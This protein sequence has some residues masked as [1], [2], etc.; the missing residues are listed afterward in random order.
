MIGRAAVTT[1]RP[2][3]DLGL[4]QKSA[5]RK[6]QNNFLA[7]GAN[8]G[9]ERCCSKISRVDIGWKMENRMHRH[10]L[11]NALLRLRRYYRSR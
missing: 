5:S 9:E 6:N 2:Q 4:D 10:N 8:Y 11:R 3:G 7:H 1:A